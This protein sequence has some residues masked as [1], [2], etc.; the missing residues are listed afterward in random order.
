[1]NHIVLIACAALMAVP[2]CATAQ[3]SDDPVVCTVGNQTIRQSEL[4]KEFNGGMGAQ[5]SR[6]A[7]TEQER[8]AALE[9]YA[10]LYSIFKAKVIDAHALG[11][12]TTTRLRKELAA[13][14]HDLAVPYLIDSAELR[15]LLTEAYERNHTSLRAAHMLIRFPLDC[16]PEDTLVR[17]KRAMEAWHRLVENGEDWNTVVSDGKMPPEED[18]SVSEIAGDVGYFSVFDMIY[19][20]EN[21][22]YSLKVGE[23]SKPVRTQYGYHIIRL[24]DRVEGLAGRVSLA[25]IWYNGAD[26]NLRRSEIYMTYQQLQDGAKFEQLARQ[27]DDRSTAGAGGALVDVSLSQILPEY[28][29]QLA[30]LKV[31]EF[32]RPFFT[33]YGWHIVKLLHRDTLPSPDNLESFYKQRLARDQR[34]SNSRKSFAAQSRAKYGIIDCTT[35]PVKTAKTKGRKKVQPRMMANY[36]ELLRVIPD[37]V[38]RAKYRFDATAFSDTTAM[39]ITPSHRY[40]SLDV[41][42]YIA[43]HQEKGSLINMGVYLQGR[44]EDFLDSVSIAYAESQLENEYPEFAA[45]I[46]EYRRGLM[47]F[48]YNDEMIWR[49]AQNDSAG[50]ADYYARESVKKD[51]TKKEDSVFFF[52][53]RARVTLID[54][55]SEEAIAPNKAQAIVEKAHRKGLGSNDIK[56]MLLKKVNRK[57]YSGDQPV[58]IDVDQVERYK[59][60]LL[61]DDQWH[62]GVY[63]KPANADGGYRIIVVDEIIPRTLKGQMDAR[64]YYLNGWQN[65]VEQRVNKYLRNKYNIKVNRDVL[66]KIRL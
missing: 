36:D 10:D 32:S 66:A 59:Q 45:L 9:E 29:H 13:Y 2:M 5:L 47:I 11:F 14:R 37:S 7:A 16:T 18:P 27:S 26:S 39:V 34:H 54:I 63:L 15:R 21:A 62:E 65:E 56:N 49:K 24:L 53:I 64:G 40:T 57:K 31:G 1:M 6:S 41:G 17:Y 46:D 61:T 4:M 20:F 38:R 25:H 48:N 58:A 50:F 35:T 12:D 43:R 28:V 30:T 33:R 51:V 42:K 55:A 22:A 3:Q 19:P 8:R 52:N 23:I 44:F 60:S